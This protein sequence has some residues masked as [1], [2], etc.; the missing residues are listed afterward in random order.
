M[1]RPKAEG[2]RKRKAKDPN[3]P[4]RATSAYFFFLS[5]MREDSKKAGKPI[6]KIA[7]FTKDCSAKWAKMNEKD[8]EPFA[9]KAETDKK[10]YDAEM[11]IYKGKDPN[12]AGKPKRPQ[13]AYFCFLADFRGKMKGKDIDHKEIIKMAGEA[14]RNLDDNEKKPFEKLAQ[15]EQ[16]K[17]EQALS[18]WRKGGGGAS[19]S[20]KAKQEENGDEDEDEEEEEEEDDDEDDE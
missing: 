14:W 11:A 4:K 3:R 13:S 7:E 2:S 12:D 8:K 17:Y 19:P 10:R 6:T 20:K 1:G 16:E 5:K 15:K 9:K 18:D